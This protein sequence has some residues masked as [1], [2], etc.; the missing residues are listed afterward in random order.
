M[1]SVSEGAMLKR[2][3]LLRQKIAAGEEGYRPLLELTI[4]AIQGG[5]EP[6]PGPWVK[7]QS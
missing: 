3:T 4:K 1:E 7:R 2:L 5:Y 6:K